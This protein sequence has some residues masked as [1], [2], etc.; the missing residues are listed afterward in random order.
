[1]MWGTGMG[2]WGWLA[3]AGVTALLW[4][5]VVLVIVLLL[6]VRSTKR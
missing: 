2:W 4:C 5:L 6:D 1:M 3:M